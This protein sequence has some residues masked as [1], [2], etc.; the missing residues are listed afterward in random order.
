MYVQEREQLILQLQQ[1]RE[2]VFQA[3]TDFAKAHHFTAYRTWQKLS[4][5]VFHWN[6]ERDPS[7]LIFGVLQPYAPELYA[8]HPNRDV[9]LKN[10]IQCD[11]QP[12]NTL[13]QKFDPLSCV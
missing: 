6:F 2:K 5:D 9:W 4:G 12:Q 10:W 1:L 11:Q 8:I 7:R 3:M 13:H